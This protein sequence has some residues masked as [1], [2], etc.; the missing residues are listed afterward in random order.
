ME[1]QR[2]IIPLSTPT[3]SKNTLK[4]KTLKIISPNFHSQV[5]SS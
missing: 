4:G 3:L 5:C 2:Q 1:L